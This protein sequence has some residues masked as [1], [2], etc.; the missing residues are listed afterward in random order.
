MVDVAAHG[1]TV[2]SVT[3]SSAFDLSA[4]LEGYRP[5]GLSLE[6]WQLVRT[7]ALDLVAR[8]APS[9]QTEARTL[10]SALT[11]Y[12]QRLRGSA[13][14]SIDLLTRDGLE[15]YIE[16]GV[17]K[18][19]N[20]GSL[21][22]VAARLKRLLAAH[23]G[24]PKPKKGATERVRVKPLHPYSDAEMMAIKAAVASAAPE[25][26]RILA[27]LVTLVERYGCPRAELTSARVE[28]GCLQLISRS[29]PLG[30]D[31]T[32]LSAC[33]GIPLGITDDSW[34]DARAAVKAAT[35][36]ALEHHRLRHRWLQSLVHEPG[37]VATL[38]LRHGL[39]RDDIALAVASP[40]MPTHRDQTHM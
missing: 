28:D 33:S 15:R 25:T 36:A 4:Y 38:I 29:V 20:M 26:S 27:L 11:K 8:L 31:D 30:S 19:D 22:Q 7:P 14:A 2:L 10:L 37:P 39:S 3:T 34:A 24:R 17:I 13:D 32:V 18:G 35:G 12:L 23:E 5:Q 9:T 40:A 6:Q 1:R 16:M 21:A